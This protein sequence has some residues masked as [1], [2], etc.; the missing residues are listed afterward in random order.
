MLPALVGIAGVGSLI[1][2]GVMSSAESSHAAVPAALPTFL[3]AAVAVDPAAPI[4]E[5][6]GLTAEVATASGCTAGDAQALITAIES[7]QAAVLEIA[8]LDEDVRA[9]GSELVAALAELDTEPL[10]QTYMV[11]VQ[12][13]KERL[14]FVEEQL[15]SA[16][17]ALRDAALAAVGSDVRLLCERCVGHAG[18]TAPVE[19]RVL[20]WDAES[21]GR[22]ELALIAERRATRM[23]R[24]L[25][26]ED[27]EVIDRARSDPG[28]IHA[29]VNLDSHLASVHAVYD[30]AR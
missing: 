12:A 19:C 6:L 3:A 24:D 18:T 30:A 27:A 28:V 26:D 2:L 5:R 4:A 1:T 25:A 11:R 17:D 9:A 23:N 14:S 22:L 16:L 20:P 13:A 21:L 29:R 10:N 15:N 8:A 7:N